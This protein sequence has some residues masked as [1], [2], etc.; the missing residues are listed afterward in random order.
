MH[1]GI[2]MLLGGGLLSLWLSGCAKKRPEPQVNTERELY[3]FDGF[4]PLDP[5]GELL[6]K[7]YTTGLS[8]RD[9]DRG[10]ASGAGRGDKNLT[11]DELRE[12][13]RDLYLKQPDDPRYED[14]VHRVFPRIANAHFRMGQAHFRAD[15]P[16]ET[17]GCRNASPHFERAALFD[18]ARGDVLFHAALCAGDLGSSVDYLNRLLR[19]Q[20]DFPDAHRELGIALYYS[21]NLAGAR[22]ALESALG[23]HPED[24]DAWRYLGSVSAHADVGDALPKWREALRLNPRHHEARLLLALG[25]ISVGKWHEG[26]REL[27]NL[28]GLSPDSNAIFRALREADPEL[29]ERISEASRRHPKAPVLSFFEELRRETRIPFR[30]PR[31]SKRKPDIAL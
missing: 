11:L 13:A 12:T 10:D 1:P 23:I 7:L 27:D 29:L 17:Q 14:L 8:N 5:E 15:R 26:R 22:W 16:Q 28:E 30:L 4:T 3:F 9:L 21:G 6:D 18:P 2:G 19:L 25:L 24:A 20:P 31:L